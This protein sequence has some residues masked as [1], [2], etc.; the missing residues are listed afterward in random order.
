MAG[1]VGAS[2]DLERCFVDEINICALATDASQF[3]TLLVG[4]PRAPRSLDCGSVF[5]WASTSDLDCGY[6]VGVWPGS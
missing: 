6:R 5:T 1:V 3:L 2:S 4:G